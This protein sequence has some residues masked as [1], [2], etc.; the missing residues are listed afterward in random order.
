MKNKVIAFLLLLFTTQ[1][2]ASTV[3]LDPAIHV[4]EQTIQSLQAE[5]GLEK[6]TAKNKEFQVEMDKE[7]SIYQKTLRHSIENITQQKALYQ[8]LLTLLA[9]D[10]STDPKS[11]EKL[12][13]KI[14]QVENDFKSLRLE[15]EK[16]EQEMKLLSNRMRDLMV[17]DSPKPLPEE[18]WGQFQESI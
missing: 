13:E 4:M 3:N 18:W 8:N 10:A 1:L 6:P 9:P 17:T 15:H 11:L 14:S 5:L 7:F 16:N 12:S 2:A